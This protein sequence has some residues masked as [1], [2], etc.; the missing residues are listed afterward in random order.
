ME[1]AD[2]AEA[3]LRE[4]LDGLAVGR[5]LS[6]YLTV[7][8]AADLIRSRPQRVYDLVSSGRLSRFKDGSR[9]LVLRAEVERWLAGER[10]GPVART[11]PPG[12]RSRTRSEVAG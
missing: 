12:A 5:E 4:R 8:E 1:V 7:A 10:T 9:T 3:M 2:R 11:L 6:P